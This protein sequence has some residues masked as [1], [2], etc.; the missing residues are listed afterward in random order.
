MQSIDCL[1]LFLVY[2]SFN[3]SPT[4]IC[5]GKNSDWK[6]KHSSKLQ[7]WYENNYCLRFLALHNAVSQWT[8]AS[9]SCVMDVC[10]LVELR[11]FRCARQPGTDSWQEF[12]S[13]AA[14]KSTCRTATTR[15]ITVCI[16]CS[17]HCFIGCSSPTQ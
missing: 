4:A 1:H 12:S 2:L 10:P 7:C 14:E 17:L 16:S 9:P 8:G 5:K 11:H 6:M 3:T 15:W 13:A